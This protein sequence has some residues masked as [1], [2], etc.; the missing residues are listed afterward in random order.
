MYVCTYAAPPSIDRSR[1]RDSIVVVGE[2]ISFQ[3]SARGYPP[4]MITWFLNEAKVLP[5]D[6]GIEVYENLSR[7]GP[8][9]VTT[10]KLQITPAQKEQ[11]GKVQCLVRTNTEIDLPKFNDNETVELVVLGKLVGLCIN[12]SVLISCYENCITFPLEAMKSGMHSYGD[13]FNYY[14]H[15]YSYSL[16]IHIVSADNP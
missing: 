1:L 15:H 4:P 6:T 11:N 13:F 14:V 9:N 16:S 12:G 5:Q 10:S 3:C 8:Y 7:S 2:N